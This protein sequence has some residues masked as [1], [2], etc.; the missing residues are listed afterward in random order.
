[1][2]LQ[3]LQLRPARRLARG[4]GSTGVGMRAV[5]GG[6]LVA[7]LLGWSAWLCHR[8]SQIAATARQPHPDRTDYQARFEADQKRS[9]P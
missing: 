4:A 1:V 9:M 5:L 7:A 6:L 3:A 8:G 2:G